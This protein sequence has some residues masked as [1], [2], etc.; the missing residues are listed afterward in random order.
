MDMWTDPNLSPFMAVTAH[1]IEAKIISTP[2][3]TQYELKLRA[4]LIGF[5]SV[6]GHHTGEHMAHAFLYVLD[7]IG[8]AEK[9]CRN[10][11]FLLSGWIDSLKTS[12]LDGLPLTTLLTMIRS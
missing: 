5:H 12:R 4:D 10:S 7:R 1:W 2:Q 9:V 3:G 6:P 11:I 8:I